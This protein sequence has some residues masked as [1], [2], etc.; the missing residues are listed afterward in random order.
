MGCCKLGY[1]L[2]L[3]LMSDTVLDDI[4]R[5]IRFDHSGTLS[6]NLTP[7]S[8]A[9]IDSFKPS[10]IRYPIVSKSHPATLSYPILS[11]IP[12][13]THQPGFEAGGHPMTCMPSTLPT[14]IYLYTV[15]GHIGGPNIEHKYIDMYGLCKPMQLHKP[16]V[17]HYQIKICTRLCIPQLQRYMQAWAQR[18]HFNFTLTVEGGQTFFLAH[19]SDA[20]GLLKNVGKT[21]LH[22]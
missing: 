15:W 20:T 4:S 16:Y 21:A 7:S 5:K 1:M 6:H 18:R 2:F 11:Y 14:Y 22:M 8:A 17:S 9:K 19:F 3:E 10:I 12:L 13:E